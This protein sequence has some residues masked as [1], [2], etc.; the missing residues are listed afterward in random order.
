MIKLL[1]LLGFIGIVCVKIHRMSFMKKLAAKIVMVYGM[2]GWV[3][4][5]FALL[6]FSMTELYEGKY[7]NSREERLL[8]VEREMGRGEMENAMQDMNVYKS[9][10]ADFEYAWERCAMY[11]AYNL[12]SLFSQASAANPAYA[13]EAERC[14]QQVLQICYD[15]S[16]PENEPYVELYLQELE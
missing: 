13:S 10:E 16:C 15:S 12:Y 6:L 1:I 8:R 7:G 5:G 11:R 4:L 9:Y 2:L 14:R 3:G